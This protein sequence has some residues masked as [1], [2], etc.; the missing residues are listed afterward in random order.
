[1]KDYY[2]FIKSEFPDTNVVY[3]PISKIIASIPY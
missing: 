2:N 1:M 3:K